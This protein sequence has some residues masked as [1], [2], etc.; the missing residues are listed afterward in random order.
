MAIFLKTRIP[1]ANIDISNYIQ[2]EY[3]MKHLLLYKRSN[4]HHCSIDFSIFIFLLVIINH[5]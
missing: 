5:V 1:I 4:K 2:V 3:V